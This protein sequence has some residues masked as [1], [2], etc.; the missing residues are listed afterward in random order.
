MAKLNL[1]LSNL[2]ELN[3]INKYKIIT[4]YILIKIYI[5]IKK[6][7]IFI[8]IDIKVYISVIIKFLIQTLG[9]K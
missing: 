2:K 5:R 3:N 1:V 7:I 9:F 4:K 6:N 8:I